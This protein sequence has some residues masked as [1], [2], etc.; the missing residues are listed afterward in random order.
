MHLHHRTRG[1]SPTP[2]TNPQ[3][4]C[5]F[6][7]AVLTT[8]QQNHLEGPLK[9]GSAGPTCVLSHHWWGR[10]A[11]QAAPTPGVAGAGPRATERQAPTLRAEG[12]P[13]PLS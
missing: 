7:S 2:S 6:K 13:V 1:L 3:R 9:A 8:P 12:C 4:L 5:R 10:G 11:G